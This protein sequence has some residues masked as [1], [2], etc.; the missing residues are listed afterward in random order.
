MDLVTPTQKTRM[1]VEDIKIRAETVSDFKEIDEINQ[2]A[3]E[4]DAEVILVRSLRYNPG[5]IPELSLVAEM[6]EMLVGH[7]LMF[8]VPIKKS[9][10]IATVLSLGPMAVR[11]D[12]QNQGV[13]KRLAKAGLE[14]GK[15]LGFP[16]AI[17]L[18]H[19]GFYPK[20]GFSPAS[21][22]D[23]KCPFDAPDEAFMALELKEG[24]LE[25]ISGEVIYPEEFSQTI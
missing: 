3:F 9:A 11:P 1:S 6:G 19:P 16:A 22:W 2:T 18:G 23:I 21:K 10:G 13:G 25:N 20:F 12:C 24:T 14:S 17:V 5:F 15:I 4:G 8:P 7:I